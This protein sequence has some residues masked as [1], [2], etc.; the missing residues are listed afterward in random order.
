[1]SDSGTEQNQP[2]EAQELRQRRV[3]S[4][5]SEQQPEDEWSTQGKIRNHSQKENSKFVL[6]ASVSVI[7]I[8]V[9]AGFIVSKL[10]K[11]DQGI[12]G[13]VG[14]ELTKFVPP[15][16]NVQPIVVDTADDDLQMWYNERISD[17]YKDA[18]QLIET[19]IATDSDAER[20]LLLRTPESSLPLINQWPSIVDPL[21]NTKDSDKWAF[22]ILEIDD[23]HYLVFTGKRV[24]FSEFRYYFVRD[25]DELK[26]DWQATAAYS[27]RRISSHIERPF[28]SQTL[29]RGVLSKPQIYLGPYSDDK[30]WSSFEIADPLG[31][32]SLW[33]YV[34]KSS[35]LEEELLGWMDYGR[36]IVELNENVRGTFILKSSEAPD[37]HPKQVEIVKAI[38]KGWLTP[39]SSNSE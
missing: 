15:E 34:P 18:A 28:E 4:S 38:H 29:V 14:V 22:T 7:I 13:T 37:A 24:D 23:F 3:P 12:G 21:P 8:L 32:E 19:F 17:L 11:E 26:L 31:G 35:E 20:A 6:I 33:A 2:N 5:R 16:Q 9:V 30:K 25:G 39:G 1:M 10:S 27:Q 36:F